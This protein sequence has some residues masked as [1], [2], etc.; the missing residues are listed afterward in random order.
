MLLDILLLEY[1]VGEKLLRM[2]LAENPCYLTIAFWQ[3]L[4]VFT[5]RFCVAI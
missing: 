1:F 5:N 2:K 4:C 3:R